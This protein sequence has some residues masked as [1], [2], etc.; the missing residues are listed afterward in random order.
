MLFS[1]PLRSYDAAIFCRNTGKQ[2]AVHRLVADC[3]N[4]AKT[5]AGLLG[6]GG[7]VTLT[8]LTDCGTQV[9][10]GTMR[11]GSKRWTF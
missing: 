1:N 11:R 3:D 4:S 5:A 2:L 10:V 6:A 8:R 7:A 9:Y